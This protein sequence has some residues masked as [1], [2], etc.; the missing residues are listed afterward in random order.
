MGLLDNSRFLVCPYKDSLNIIDT[1]SG[2]KVACA[3]LDDDDEISSFCFTDCVLVTISKSMLVKKW[4]LKEVI[5][6]GDEKDGSEEIKLGKSM[7]DGFQNSKVIFSL[8]T[9]GRTCKFEFSLLVNKTSMINM[10]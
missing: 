4:S 10:Y 3:K 8:T 7:I 9:Q 6:I 1:Q 5:D 2:M